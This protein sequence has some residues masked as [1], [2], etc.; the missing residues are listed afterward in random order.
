[1]KLLQYCS[2]GVPHSFV[3]LPLFFLSFSAGSY[4]YIYIH[5][6]YRS[7]NHQNRVYRYTTKTP[8]LSTQIPR[9]HFFRDCH[10]LIVKIVK[11]KGCASK[12]KLKLYLQCECLLSTVCCVVMEDDFVHLAPYLGG[13]FEVCKV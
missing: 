8:I 9:R 12:S 3:A 10:S 13:S 5:V 7:V 2:A 4:I 6:L 1:M 11:R